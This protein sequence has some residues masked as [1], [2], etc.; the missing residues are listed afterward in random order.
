M[1]TVAPVVV[2]QP[3]ASFTLR[4]YEPAAKPV[5]VL[6]VWKLPPFRE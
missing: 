3:F 4:V 5:K 6:E 2:M 1:V